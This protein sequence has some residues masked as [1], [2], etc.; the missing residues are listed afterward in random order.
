MSLQIARF[1]QDKAEGAKVAFIGGDTNQDDATQNPRPSKWT[2]IWDELKKYPSTL[3]D[4]TVDII[5]SYDEDGRVK[6]KSG[7]VI[8]LGLHSDH[9]TIEAV[10]EVT[11]LPAR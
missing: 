1:L 5:A 8:P 9:K 6:A 4:R 7:R 11:A 3:G 10:Y 2:T